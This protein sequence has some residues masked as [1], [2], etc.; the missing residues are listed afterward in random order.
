M[1]SPLSRV[2]ILL[3]L[4]AAVACAPTSEPP[5]G[6]DV[7]PAS[8]SPATPPAA[9]P[10]ESL[11]SLHNS[12][13]EDSTRQVIRT[14]AEW[15]QAWERMHAPYGEKPA[16]PSVD[17][18]RSV[19]VVAAMGMRSSGGFGIA[20]DSV[21]RRDGG[22]VVHVTST[23]PGRTCGTTGALTQPVA[24]ARVDATDQQVRFVERAVVREC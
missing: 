6:S 14:S 4:A 20:I 22:L 18:A 8:Q 10:V 7:P 9:V 21:E 5:S 23:S 17:F 13:I 16:L 1:P 3:P 11:A 19:V 2:A 15:A 24:A 12:G